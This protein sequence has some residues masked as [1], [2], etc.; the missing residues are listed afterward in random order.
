[1]KKSESKE[2]NGQPE[3]FTLKLALDSGEAELNVTFR[4]VELPVKVRAFVGDWYGGICVRNKD[5]S[6]L[7]L[8]VP[9]KA[10]VAELKMADGRTVTG[11]SCCKPPDYFDKKEGVR[12][13][14]K[15]LLRSVDAKSCLAPTDYKIVRQAPVFSKRKSLAKKEA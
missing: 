5:G 1:M 12:L 7:K 13:A 14:V 15:R 4:I 9:V 3:N 10:V 2:W 11:R 6:L 8:P